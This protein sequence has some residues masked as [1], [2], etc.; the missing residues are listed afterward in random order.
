MCRVSKLSC[1]CKYLPKKA[2]TYSKN[3]LFYWLQIL[4]CII[5]LWQGWVVGFVVFPFQAFGPKSALV[6]SDWMLLVLDGSLVEPVK[7]VGGFSTLPSGQM[8]IPLKPHLFGARY[9]H[10]HWE[11]RWRGSRPNG[12]WKSLHADISS[13]PV[14]R[15][16]M[17]NTGLSGPAVPIYLSEQGNIFQLLDQAW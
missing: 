10:S 2:I 4:Q 11:S 1:G 5:D 16:S 3:P 12:T 17:E 6:S 9:I 15:H 8:P 14:L 7:W 13:S